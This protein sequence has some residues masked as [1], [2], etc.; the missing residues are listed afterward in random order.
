MVAEGADTIYDPEH[1]V[2]ASYIDPRGYIGAVSNA[3]RVLIK[4]GG[5]M[6][7]V[8]TADALGALA[9]GIG[10]GVKGLIFGSGALV[11]AAKGAFATG[12]GASVRSALA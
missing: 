2:V 11:E 9:G 3:G 1:W 12:I 5:Q 10:N 6:G 7:D 8:A 4:T